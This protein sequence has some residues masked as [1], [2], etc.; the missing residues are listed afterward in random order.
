MY[1]ACYRGVLFGMVFM[2]VA[3]PVGVWNHE[4]F[5]L[6]NGA[7]ST[8]G[9]VVMGIITGFGDGLVVALMISCIMLFRLRLGL[10]ALIAFVVSGLIGQI[11]K[12]IF[13]MP[14]PPAVMENV[15]VL[16]AALQSHSFPSGHAT[17]C[18]VMFLLALALW[19][20]D[21]W[22]AWVGATVFAVAAYGR[23]YVGVHFPFDVWV[24][25]GIGMFCFSAARHWMMCLPKG[26]WETNE[27]GWKIPA[28]ILLVEAAV[29]GLG[30][31]IQPST[32]DLLTLVVPVAALVIL[33]QFWKRKSGDE[34][35]E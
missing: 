22:Q 5:S 16:G 14:R 10:A 17:S 3:V 20:R 27:W 13:D 9:D 2:L 26:D 21:Q 28:T 35:T 1:P 12:R 25:F 6:L 32:A 19:R 34:S 24:G 33:M 4:L 8:V 18:G 7:N 15:H 11:L 23:V 30:Y 31:R 29:L